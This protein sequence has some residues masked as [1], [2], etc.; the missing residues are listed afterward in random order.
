MYGDDQ[1][2]KF[3]KVFILKKMTLLIVV[4]KNVR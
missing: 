1:K 4:L 3:I 2:E